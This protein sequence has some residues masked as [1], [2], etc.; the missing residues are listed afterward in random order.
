MSHGELSGMAAGYALSALDPEDLEIFG[1]H[2]VSCQ[3]CQASVAGMG[4]LVDSLS[5]MA[6]DA[7][8]V[9]SL[10][11][12][13]LAAARAEPGGLETAGRPIPEKSVPWWR[14][15]VL[16]PLPAGA[17]IMLLVAAIAVVSV[18]GS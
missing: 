7:V 18:W 1:E 8:P 14:R 11:E 5:M 15:P 17:L 4:P 6:E 16:W 12:R 13:I 3:E 2:L 10:R 9:D